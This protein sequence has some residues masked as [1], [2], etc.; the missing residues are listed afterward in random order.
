MKVV[1][2]F[3]TKKVFTNSLKGEKTDTSATPRE[4]EKKEENS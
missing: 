3:Q 4:K 2:I 1:I